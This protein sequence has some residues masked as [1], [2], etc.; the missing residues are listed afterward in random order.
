MDIFSRK[1]VLVQVVSCC[2]NKI[3]KQYLETVYEG[4]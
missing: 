3:P 1:Y 4:Q 2:I